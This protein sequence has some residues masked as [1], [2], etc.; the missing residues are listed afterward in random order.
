MTLSRMKRRY[1]S[2]YSTP[3]EIHTVSTVHTLQERIRRMFASRTTLRTTTPYTKTCDPFPSTTSR[4]QR[5]VTGIKVLS[6]YNTRTTDMSEHYPLATETMTNLLVTT[7]SFS[8]VGNETKVAKCNTPWNICR[9]WLALL[10]TP[11]SIGRVILPTTFSTN[12]RFTLYY[13]P[14]RPQQFIL[15]PEQH[16]FNTME[17][18]PPPTR[19]NTPAT[20]SPLS[21]LNTL[22]TGVRSN[23]S[24]GC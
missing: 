24:A 14:D 19:P 3:A 6:T 8:T 22:P 11:V 16:P 18:R 17:K 13:P 21:N 10:D 20:N 2:S 23:R 12:R 5:P 7:F 15:T 9:R 4:R 1:S